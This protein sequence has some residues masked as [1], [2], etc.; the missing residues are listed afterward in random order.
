MTKFKDRATCLDIFDQECGRTFN[1][2]SFVTSEKKD[3]TLENFLKII[4][5]CY[6]IQYLH[7][8]DFIEAI[9]CIIQKCVNIVT[10][11]NYILL[12]LFT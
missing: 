2:I 1:A 11:K 6:N 7:V 10:N 5:D 8:E 3:E 12:Y 4:I 9:V